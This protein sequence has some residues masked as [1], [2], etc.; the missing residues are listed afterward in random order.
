MKNKPFYQITGLFIPMNV[1]VR[2]R[3]NY[4]IGN[5]GCLIDGFIFTNAHGI[6]WI[7]GCAILFIDL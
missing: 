4:G 3:Y 7:E 2:V 6:K 1:F 5:S